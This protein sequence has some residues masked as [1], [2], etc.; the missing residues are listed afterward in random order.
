[1]AAEELLGA[2][3]RS[4]AQGLF[5]ERFISLLLIHCSFSLTL[6]PPCRPQ[7]SSEYLEPQSISKQT[8]GL[9]VPYDP[10]S[11]LQPFQPQTQ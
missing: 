9:H 4:P 6:R 1:M 10:S 8:H 3:P 2:P 11:P 5:S 7:R